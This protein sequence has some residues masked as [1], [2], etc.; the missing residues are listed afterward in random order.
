MSEIFSNLEIQQG[1]F[2]YAFAT[3]AMSMLI[4]YFI[5]EPI[6]KKVQDN[7]LERNRRKWAKQE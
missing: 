7:H 2:W 4:G 1:V 6:A 5:S 3:V